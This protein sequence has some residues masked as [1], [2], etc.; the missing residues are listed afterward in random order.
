MAFLKNKN[1]ANSADARP[2]K[3][4]GRTSS[5]T[6]SGTHRSSR[7]SSN[8]LRKMISGIGSF[9][10]MLKLTVGF[11]LTIS[12]LLVVGIGYLMI[13]KGES[14]RNYST[15]ITHISASESEVNAVLKNFQRQNLMN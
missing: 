4:G 12:G 14:L 5:K 6:R 10:R 1:A 8:F 9:G 11:C 2:G 13:R 7:K 15:V 3:P